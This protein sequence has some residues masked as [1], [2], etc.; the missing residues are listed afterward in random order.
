MCNGLVNILVLISLP[1]NWLNN[2]NAIADKA[3]DSKNAMKQIMMLSLINQ[4]SSQYLQLLRTIRCQPPH[5]QEL[6]KIYLRSCKPLI[7]LVGD[8]LH[9]DG[10][11]DISVFRF[12][13]D[14]LMLLL[15]NY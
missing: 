14:L 10:N 1:A 3:R 13:F 9:A 8:I 15:L 2:G 4:T 11:L 5:D 6:K 7:C 12:E